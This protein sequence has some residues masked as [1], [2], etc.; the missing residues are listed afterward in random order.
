MRRNR[1]YKKYH[2]P[3]Q[4]YDRVDLG[5]FIN[6]VM[7]DGKKSVAEA[8]VY[9]ALDHIKE[10]SGEDPIEVF[11]KAIENVSPLLEV[12]SRRVGGANYQVPREVRPARRFMLAIRWIV[13]AARKKTGKPMY[14]KLADELLA[15]SRNDGPAIKKKQDMHRMAEANRAFAHFAR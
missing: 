14:L 7:H 3:D 8:V 12:S 13:D 10:T 11:E 1:V 9:G 2:T 4:V 6:A 15:A 5:R